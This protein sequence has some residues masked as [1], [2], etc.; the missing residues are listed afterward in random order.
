MISNA[1]ATIR[2]AMSFFPLL[3]PFIIKL[4]PSERSHEHHIRPFLCLTNA[5]VDQAL[6]N[7]HL[8]LLELLLGITTSGVGEIY[9]MADLDVVGKGDVLHLDTA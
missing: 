2:T 6:N 4:T 3:R 5:P 1:C 7:G 8:S 9:G